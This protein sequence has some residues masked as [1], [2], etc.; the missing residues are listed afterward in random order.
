MRDFLRAAKLL[1]VDLAS[2][3]FFLALYFLT[4]NTTLAVSLGMALGVTQI[5]AQFIRRKPIHAMEWLSLVLVLGSG[6]ATLLTDDLRFVLFKPS[7]IYLI[8]GV[9]MLKPGWTNRYVPPIVIAVASDVGLIAGFVWAAVMFVSAALNA[10]L[11]LACT[12][13]TWA[14]VM[15]AFGIVSKLVVFIGTYLAIRLTVVR[16][17]R[18][19]PEGER[20]ALLRSTGLGPPPSAGSSGDAG[21]AAPA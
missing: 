14:E 15:P 8:A 13:Q 16:R 4:H 18:A 10:F 19:M 20:E 1:V 21:L 12:V 2:T 5:A 11:A 9:V 17:V 3:L 6:S 7:V